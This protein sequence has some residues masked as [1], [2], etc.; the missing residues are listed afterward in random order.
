MKN[1]RI[2]DINLNGMPKICVPVTGVTENEILGE[3]NKLKNTPL[4]L[5]E[6]RAD[7]FEFVKDQTKVTDLLEKIRKLYDKPLLFTLRTKKEGGVSYINTDYYFKLNKNVIE[8][9][10]VELIDIEFFSQAEGVDSIVD[11]ARKNMVVTI[12]SNHDFLKT[13]PEEEIISRVNK[14]MDCG[15]IA[16]IAVMPNSEEDVLT[17][18][19][20][21]L[22]LKKEKKG[23]FIAISMGPLGI[24][25]RISCELI[26]SCMTY[27]SH[28]D[29]SAPGQIDVKLIK[30]IIKIMHI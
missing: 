9:K 2:K 30:E 16:K 22:K 21:A 3:F 13:P 14:M 7:Y 1:I 11:L 5:V 10:L 29:K 6:L 28:K 18:L 4:D 27:A 25:S 8:S 17:L 12:L 23:P 24:I 20:A 15:D 26:G 19:S